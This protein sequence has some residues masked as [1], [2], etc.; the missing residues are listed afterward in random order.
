MQQYGTRRLGSQSVSISGMAG[1][2]F[3]DEIL[4]R[5]TRTANVAQFVSFDARLSQRH[6]WLSGFESNH[7]F[8]STEE[9]VR[10]MLE[11]SPEQ[12]VNIRTFEAALPKSREFVYGLRSV[13]DVLDRLQALSSE[14]L[15]T[16][17]CVE[18]P[19]T[20]AFPRE[21]AMRLF[22]TVYGAATASILFQRGSMPPGQ[23]PQACRPM[24]RP[25]VTL[26]PRPRCR[27]QRAFV[28][29]D[30]SRLRPILVCA[31]LASVWGM[32]V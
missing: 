17:R 1:P 22:D 20:A 16:P 15:T 28:I 25:S 30:R 18:K 5:L 19:G 6:A 29:R 7:R 10:T 21:I 27:D 2:H 3:K 8:R 14:G 11:H 23:G 13:S 31:P 24:A 9:A 26:L 32:V 4:D 12:S